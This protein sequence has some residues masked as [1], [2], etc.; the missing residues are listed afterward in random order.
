MNIEHIRAFLEVTATGS[1]QLTA[2]KLN[3]TQS[4]ISARI[5]ALEDR[6]RRE[7]FY[8]KR[9]GIALTAGGHQFHASAVNIVRA[10]ERGLQIVSLPD[11]MDTVIS[12]GVDENHWLRVVP[13]WLAQMDVALPNIAASVVGAS[14]GDLMSQLKA[15]LLDLAVLYDPQHCPEVSV[16]PLSRDRLILVSTEPRKVESGVVPGY[17]YV[18]WGEAF[19]EQHSLHFPSVFSHKL[20]VGSGIV[21]REHII[22]H[23]GSGYLLES[24]TA[25]AIA[26]GRLHVVENAPVFERHLFLAVSNDAVDLASLA[27]AAQTIRGVVNFKI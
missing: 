8:R 7:L 24:L 5:K 21:A 25:Q 12:L 6:L 20:T 14:S 1:F 22:E 2:E 4:T 23:D 18:D 17:I 10:W 19:R 26:A 27:V 9:N 13:G 16:E 11:G 15:G 3:V